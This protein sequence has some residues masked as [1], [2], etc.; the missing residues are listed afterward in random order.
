M[1]NKTLEGSEAVAEVVKN[2]EPEVIACFPI[3]PST[4]IAEDLAQMYSDGKIKQYIAV[5]SEFS[6]I[7]AMAGASAAGGRTFSA[8]SSQGLALMHEILFAAAGMRLPMV[9]VVANRSLS[10][11]LSIW[12][13]HQDTISERDSGWIQLYCESNQEAVDTVPQAFKISESTKIPVMVCMDGFYLT[14]SVEQIDVP[15]TEMIRK[16]LPPFN[17][18]LKLDSNKPIT[19]GSYAFPEHYQDFRKDLEEDMIKSEGTIRKAHDEWAKLSG[20]GYGNGLWEGANLEEAECVFVGMSSVMGNA[21]AVVE[22]EI[23]KGNRK[24][25]ALRIKSYRPFVE[26]VAELLKGK[27]SVAVFEKDIS[28]GGVP[29]LYSE[30]LDSLYHLEEKERPVLSSFI[31]GLGGR[32]VTREVIR[33]VFKKTEQQEKPLREFV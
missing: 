15:E 21:K 9:L 1:A 30:I 8:T 2:C 12:N 7:S 26:E 28:F 3:T 31:G 32:D 27:K 4:H 14:H 13:D 18:E 5:E 20:R 24:Y 19:L 29:P 17:P 10:A 23:N 25:G 16:F 33:G 22:S 11:P 6:A